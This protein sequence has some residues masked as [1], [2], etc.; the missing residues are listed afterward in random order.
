MVLE[1]LTLNSLPLDF[2]RIP[3]KVI[4]IKHNCNIDSSDSS[5]NVLIRLKQ[6]VEI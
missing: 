2:S 4:L 3:I 1:F 5:N 6:I